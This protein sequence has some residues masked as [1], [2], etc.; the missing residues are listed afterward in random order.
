V[1]DIA[2]LGNAP[3]LS[4]SLSLQQSVLP[5]LVSLYSLNVECFVSIFSFRTESE[6]D[7]CPHHGSALRRDGI[8]RKEIPFLIEK[9]W[10]THIKIEM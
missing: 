8:R 2:T 3:R 4:L 5:S 6:S 10:I 7:T 9:K 1:P